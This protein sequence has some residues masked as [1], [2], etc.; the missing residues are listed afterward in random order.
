MCDVLSKMYQTSMKLRSDRV[1]SPEDIIKYNL[2]GSPV[3]I[4]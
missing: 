3:S 4:I 1:K 2:F